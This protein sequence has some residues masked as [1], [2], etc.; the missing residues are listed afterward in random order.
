MGL[1][2]FSVFPGWAWYHQGDTNTA[3]TPDRLPVR[4]D[5]PP[6]VEY[7]RWSAAPDAF[8]PGNQI[9]AAVVKAWVWRGQRRSPFVSQAGPA[10]ARI[11]GA[12]P[13]C[14]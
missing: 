4:P 13:S 10:S 12:L 5:Q 6:T 7:V 1:Q 2:S 11:G 3:Q 9:H 8:D 14:G